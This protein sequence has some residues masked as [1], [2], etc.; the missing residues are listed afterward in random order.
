MHQRIEKTALSGG[1]AS[2]KRNPDH[3]D[4]LYYSISEVSRMTEVKPYVLR[5]WEKEFPSLRPKKNRGGNRIYQKHEIKLINRIKDLLYEEGYT[6]DG[7]RQKLKTDKNRSNHKISAGNGSLR[8]KIREIR[9]GLK[10]LEK[11]FT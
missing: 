1:G 10:D 11:L 4:K 8:Q 6:I 3:K 9:Q 7:A 2:L 5:F